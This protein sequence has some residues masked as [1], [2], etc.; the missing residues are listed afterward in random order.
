[1]EGTILDRAKHPGAGAS[2]SY[3][4]FTFLAKEDIEA[5]QELFGNVADYVS[6]FLYSNSI[7]E[8]N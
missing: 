3:H 8:G 1:M 6:V 7:V 4:N 5:G 2:T